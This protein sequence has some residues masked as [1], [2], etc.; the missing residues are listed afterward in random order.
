MEKNSNFQSGFDRTL[1][2]QKE[3]VTVYSKTLEQRSM[4]WLAPQYFVLYY[5]FTHQMD[6]LIIRQV[7]MK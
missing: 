6:F 4:N 3:A 1:Q 2:D 5:A 7:A